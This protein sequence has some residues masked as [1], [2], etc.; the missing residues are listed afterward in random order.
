[1]DFFN[2]KYYIYWVVMLTIGIILINI[3]ISI[4]AI[5]RSPSFQRCFHDV[6]WCCVA[7][8]NRYVKL[9]AKS[10]ALDPVHTPDNT[11]LTIWHHGKHHRKN[12]D[13]LQLV[14]I[15]I[16]FSEI[17]KSWTLIMKSRGLVHILLIHLC[18]N[19]PPSDI[20]TTPPAPWQWGKY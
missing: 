2:L 13:V 16:E 11:V 12:E 3:I 4:L 9:I 19:Y 10:S 7:R 17:G 15:Q 6:K 18:S 1:M 20:T 8:C 14:K 5:D